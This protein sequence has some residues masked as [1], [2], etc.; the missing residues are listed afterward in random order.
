MAKT[1]ST[2]NTN[3]KSLVSG[4]K[5]TG[6]IVRLKNHFYKI[7]LAKKILL[8]FTI[9]LLLMIAVSLAIYQSMNGLVGTS[10]W[11]QHTHE[12]IAKGHLLQK[13]IVDL[14]TGERGFLITGN[15]VFLEPYIDAR[16]KWSNEIA[17][18][19]NMVSDNPE[20]VELI[21]SI[22]KS[23]KSWRELAAVPE[24]SM[25]RSVNEGTEEMSSV[26]ALIETK[27]GKKII[28]RLRG[29]L[30]KFVGVEEVLLASRANDAK[31]ASSEALVT[32]VFGIT[33]AL[34]IAAI[35]AVLVS[36]YIVG[37]SR[38]ILIGMKNIADGDLTQYIDVKAQDEMGALAASFNMMAN[39]IKR[40]NKSLI[41]EKENAQKATVVKSVFLANMSHEI[42]TPMAGVIGM[43]DLLMGSRLTPQQLDWA[44]SIKTSG[45]RLLDILNEILDQSKLE[46]GKIIIDP[47]DFH[48][49]SFLDD[50]C[51]GF[52]PKLDEKN[53]QFMIEI[54]EG[55]PEGVHAD[56][57]RI[58][59]IITNLLSNS[60]KFTHE[61]SIKINVAYESDE[62]VEFKLTVSI[63]DT[64]IGL[65]KDQQNNLFTAFTQADSS[66]SR[67]YGGTGLGLSISKK[68]AELMGGRI[69]VESE[70]G[71]GSRFW[72]EVQCKKAIEK[73]YPTDRKKAICKWVSSRSLKILL[74]EDTVVMQQ[75][76]IEV[77][78]SIGH[79][80]T[81]AVN[82]REA[83]E[84]ITLDDFDLVLMDIRM[85]EMDG[86][87]A[88][89]RIRAMSDIDSEL[90][91]IALTADI[92][93]GN[94]K[95]Y[96]DIGVS[97]VC[98]KPIEFTVLLKTINS[99]LKE[100]VH[101]SLPAELEILN[102]QNED[103]DEI[104]DIAGMNEVSDN[105]SQV[106]HRAADVVD[107]LS[108]LNKID[109]SGSLNVPGI[110][111]KKLSEMMA[112]YEASLSEK[113]CELDQV[114]D[115][116]MK[117]SGDEESREKLAML[118]HALKGGGDT[119]GYN[120][121]TSIATTADELLKCR[122]DLKE[123]E[124]K[125]LGHHIEALSLIAQK[126]LSGNGGKAGEILLQGLNDFAA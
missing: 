10:I 84:K 44:T 57:L 87:E 48:V 110:E 114:F 51:L 5:V 53:I 123:E 45:A 73:V 107:H 100:E 17:V 42:R 27:T 66:I 96:S 86:I 8:G 47:I 81:L 67:R 15:D 116:F 40:A 90:P 34:V 82:G 105:F 69:G 95:E 70:E 111:P 97:A 1:N 126:K 112:T 58:G 98:S 88:T 54:N 103:A 74:A 120:L 76:V 71:R 92:A 26:V 104:L 36:R 22:D 99:L 85:P 30:Q 23:E 62:A 75:L 9:P 55:V 56:R 124:M 52:R 117:S 41:M 32:I 63:S 89:Q 31:N 43:T 14:E 109:Y 91:I 24:I 11:V 25:R 79:E 6:I 7:G 102:T 49:A 61:G 35:M 93:A 101:S 16:K 3:E 19:K 60:L 125:S 68:L 77:F 65:N 118:I 50:I 78:K 12:V 122:N 80:V 13:L 72:F 119:Y 38:D 64:G 37:T 18:T 106:I 113:C 4:E 94:I 21:A 20:Q 2:N 83:V 108:R 28:D 33:L 46:A 59:Q 29:K 115:D 121:V 39:D